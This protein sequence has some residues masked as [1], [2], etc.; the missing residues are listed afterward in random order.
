MP[1]SQADED[2]K[3]RIAEQSM[4][5]KELKE[6]LSKSSAYSSSSSRTESSLPLNIPFARVPSP[7]NPGIQDDKKISLPADQH[8]QSAPVSI[9]RSVNGRMSA[10]LNRLFNGSLRDGVN[11]AILSP[12]VAED[13]LKA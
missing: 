2:A 6:M 9:I 13:L 1:V 11:Q 10:G 5:L 12:T 4:M 3:S 7:L 8:T